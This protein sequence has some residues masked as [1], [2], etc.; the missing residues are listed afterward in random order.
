MHYIINMWLQDVMVTDLDGFEK[1]LDTF[2][3]G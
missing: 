2:T 1:G 3:S